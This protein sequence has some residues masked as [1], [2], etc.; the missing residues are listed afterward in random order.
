LGSVLVGLHV[1]EQGTT[2]ASGIC[3]CYYLVLAMSSE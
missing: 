3:K 2:T 1:R